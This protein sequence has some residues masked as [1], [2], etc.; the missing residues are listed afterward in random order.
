MVFIAGISIHVL[1]LQ[2]L[3]LRVLLLQE[4]LLHVLLLQEILLH[5]LLLQELLLHVHYR[6]YFFQVLLLT[7]VIISISITRVIVNKYH[8]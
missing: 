5:V 3:L 8:Y 7:S 6:C 4:L 2:E 1:L